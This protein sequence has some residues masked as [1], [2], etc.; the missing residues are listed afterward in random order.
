MTEQIYASDVKMWGKD[1]MAY[2]LSDVL[3]ELLDHLGLELVHDRPVRLIAKT[4]DTPDT[5]GG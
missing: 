2:N 4:D 1:M 3:G 5:S